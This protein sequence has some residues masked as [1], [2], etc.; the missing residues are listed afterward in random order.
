M[1]NFTQGQKNRGD[2][3]REH[4]RAPRRFVV[5]GSLGFLIA[6][7]VFSTT[8]IPVMASVVSPS[9][10]LSTGSSATSA[11][12]ALTHSKLTGSTTRS[13]HYLPRGH[14]SRA[15]AR[16]AHVAT[17]SRTLASLKGSSTTVPPTTSPTT[18]IA[19]QQPTTTSTP[20]TTTTQA[21]PPTTT[22]PV[23]TTTIV[24]P[25]V[26]KVPQ[27]IPNPAANIAPNPNFLQTGHCNFA[28]GVWGCDNPC[29]A[30][31]ATALSWPGFTNGAACTN[32]VLQAINNARAA[33]GV[34]PM[35]LPTNWYSL[36]T[37]EQLF[38]VADLERT[39]R[40]LPAYVG[41]N[42]AL[43]A[44]AQH[45][46][47]TNNDPSVAAGFPMGN[48]AQ[49]SVGFGGAWSG[50]FTVLAADYVWMY[51]DAWA[52]SA[53]ATSNIA[54][55]SAHAAGCWAHRDELLGS[56][57]GYNPGVGLG[58]STCEMGTGFA[59]VNGHASYVDLIELP[60]GALPPMTFTWADVLPYL[61]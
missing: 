8:A 4:N 51:D 2:A 35:V 6:G 42:S 56:D 46:A 29:V 28:N 58:C 37:G 49:G 47:A 5:I 60:K 15:S 26:A 54:C 7:I 34:R 3:S 40:G 43:T 1:L 18:T 36:T 41:I 16:S 33:E 61:N 38:V 59:M 25:P 23:P 21:P 32:Y 57:P 27:S 19:N 48:D 12:N 53:A 11:I 31:S 44:D 22:V 20:V 9:T 10:S 24:K 30:G 39:A 13:H 14:G 52:G 17:S 50:G 45:A 55:T